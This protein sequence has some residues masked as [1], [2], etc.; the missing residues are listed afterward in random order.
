MDG[1]A[2]QKNFALVKLPFEKIVAFAVVFVGGDFI[3]VLGKQFNVG[4]DGP[5]FQSQMT[6]RGCSSSE[7]RLN[8]SRSASTLC[9]FS[10]IIS[11]SFCFHIITGGRFLCQVIK[12]NKIIFSAKMKADVG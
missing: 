4:I 10:A 7:Q 5:P 2:Q 8:T 3:A 11:S 9:F 1:V 12:P 6:V